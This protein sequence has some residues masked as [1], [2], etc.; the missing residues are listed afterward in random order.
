MDPQ[1]M[2]DGASAWFTKLAI[3]FVGA[4][5]AASPDPPATAPATFADGTSATGGASGEAAPGFASR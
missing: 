2:H 4:V 3:K 1:S 5:V